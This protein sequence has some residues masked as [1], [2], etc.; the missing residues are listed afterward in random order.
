MKNLTRI[1]SEEGSALLW[2]IVLMMILVVFSASVSI[3]SAQNN[4]QILHQYHVIK[5]RYIAEAGVE[6]AYQTLL[7]D[8]R[9]SRLID[10]L[11][12]FKMPRTHI[13]N[14]VQDG[15]AV[16][17][18]NAE[19]D[20]ANSDGVDWVVITSIGSLANSEIK[21]ERVLKI[22]CNNNEEMVRD[23]RIY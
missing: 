7:H 11:D 15:R 2:A 17:S 3:I 22:N 1:K 19:I 21:V 18:F 14:I 5:A 20:V 8:T 10:H 16:G 6:L 12:S 9:G 23:E 4:K 13:E